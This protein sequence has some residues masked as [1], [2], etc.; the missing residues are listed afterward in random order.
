MQEPPRTK[1]TD[2]PQRARN[3]T[4][5]LQFTFALIVFCS[6]VY[7]FSAAARKGYTVVNV[8]WA[9]E[10]GPLVLYGGFGA[11]DWMRV[12]PSIGGEPA[13]RSL[14]A[15]AH[16]LDLKV[17]SLGEP[18]PSPLRACYCS[19]RL[20]VAVRR[21]STRRT[22]GASRRRSSRRR[23]TPAASSPIPST[24]TACPL[25]PRPAGFAGPRTAWARPRCRTA[26]RAART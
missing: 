4:R 11:K 25:P 17:I 18:L 14:I 13:L 2:T 3:K 12:E 26:R 23:R 15:T 21:S 8:D 22:C 16:E 20:K 5:P 19:R 9:V 24:T 6:L 10:A 7:I 1:P